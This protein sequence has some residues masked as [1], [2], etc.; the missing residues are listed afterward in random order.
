MLQ[1]AGLAGLLIQSESVL[2]GRLIAGLVGHLLREFGVED[3][4]EGGHLTVT[5]DLGRG[6]QRLPVASTSAATEACA[7]RALAGSFVRSVRTSSRF[8]RAARRSFGTALRNQ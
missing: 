5:E 3:A 8:P 7:S 4:G 2:P 6:A 1:L